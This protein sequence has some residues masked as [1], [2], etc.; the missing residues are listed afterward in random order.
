[1]PEPQYTL[2]LTSEQ[3]NTLVQATDLYMRVLC[4]QFQVL[5][6]Q[7]IAREGVSF[8]ALD[9]ARQHL[10]DAKRLIFPELGRHP[11]ASLARVLPRRQKH[12]RLPM[13]CI[14]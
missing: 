7:F 3:A 9:A 11:G 14:K 12:R 4:G 5:A 1:M 13:I 10:A 6:E 2:T 8:E